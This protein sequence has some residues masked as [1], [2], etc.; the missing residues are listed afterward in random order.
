[1]NDFIVYKGIGDSLTVGIG[2]Y[3]SKGFVNRYAQRTVETL[4]IPVRTEV[5]AKNKI[6]SADL[7][8]RIQD[9][10]VQS[11]LMTA[12][13][14]TITIGGNDLLQ[15]NREFTRTF[16]PG[17]FDEATFSFYRNMLAV[18]AEIRFLKSLHPTPYIIRLI[19][20]YNPFPHLS[21]SDF[22]VQR[23][24]DILLSF[25]DDH[26]AFVDIY[27]YFIYGA[28]HLLNFGGL[29][30]NKYGYEIIAEAT[31]ASGYEPLKTFLLE[32]RQQ[33]KN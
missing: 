14:I 28:E 9:E 17:V 18:L 12:N 6:T 2:N 26:I 24:N 1:M 22:W 21:Y 13:I 25:E 31:A 11:R 27:P 29:H 32:H 4:Q 5:F 33:K 16:I 20:L 7:L 3:F 8:Y 30:P 10:K 23:F 19:G 15:A